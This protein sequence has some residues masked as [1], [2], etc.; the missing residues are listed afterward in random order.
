MLRT[1]RAPMER[2]FL[3]FLAL[4][5]LLDI[6]SGFA[7]YRINGSSGMVSNHDLPISL[8]VTPSLLVRM[9]LLLIMAYYV[10][11]Q[12]DRRTLFAGCAIGLTFALTVLGELFS[13]Q[14]FSL[15]ED[16][17]YIARFG[18]NLLVLLTYAA[19]L[20]R[21]FER[22]EDAAA[23]LN[24]ILCSTMFLLAGG[25]LLP[26]TL[27]MGF[28]TYSDRLGYRGCRGFFYA[29]N[30]VA[31]IAMLLL[32]LAFAVLL[33]LEKL[34]RKALPYVFA[35]GLGITTLLLL[36]T[37][38]AFLAA[39]ATVGAVLLF[40][41]I[42]GIQQKNT[43]LLRRF[44]VAVLAFLA[45]YLL[46][47]LLTGGALADTI[48]RS[49]TIAGDHVEAV[50]ASDAV[51][52]GRTDKLLAAFG[53]FKAAAPLSLLIG[54]GRGTQ[55]RIIEMDLCEV[56]LY[57]GI[58]GTITMLWIYLKNGILFLRDLFTRPSLTAWCCA[59]SL[60]LCVGYLAIAGHTLFSV[61]SGFY[62]ALIL[63]YA[64]VVCSGTA[65]DTRIV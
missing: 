18:F 8:S 39:G 22:R 9:L 33:Q 15:W 56:V 37:K 25:V 59:V 27:G 3:L 53:E 19:V 14:A 62:F 43:R 55:E 61:T 7:V 58:L 5:P 4:N 45:I 31:G 52:S 65:L 20:R 64:R 54:I 29:G 30:D 63:L 6:A 51:F 40:A 46:F 60:G 21:S 32:P 50:N 2:F 47:T 44:G 26:Y 1:T 10:L 11:R 48:L 34:D 17:L 28:Y 13:G 57:Y 35:P 36:G 49:L 23:F 12:R 16:L 41:V 24:K 42:V 38:T